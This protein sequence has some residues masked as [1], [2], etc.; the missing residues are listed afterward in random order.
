MIKIIMLNIWLYLSYKNDALIM[1]NEEDD[2]HDLTF[3]T[4]FS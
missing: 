2:D 3:V 1:F 4:L